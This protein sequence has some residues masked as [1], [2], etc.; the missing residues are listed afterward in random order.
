MAEKKNIEEIIN[1]H[2]QRNAALRQVFLDKK[3]DLTEPRRIE[4]HFWIWSEKNTTD[5]ET[6][7]KKRGFAILARSPAATPSDSRRW[8]LEAAVTQSIE[9]TMRRE[10]TDELAKLAASHDALYDGWGTSI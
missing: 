2:Q 1:D 4:C 6:S 10:F 7:L 9:L 8:N 5:L 3:I